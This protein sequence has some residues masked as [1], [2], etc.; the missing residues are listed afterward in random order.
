MPETT[1]LEWKRNPSVTPGGK[2]Y[3]WT[4]WGALGRYTAL[5]D[6]RNQCWSVELPKGD[7][8]YYVRTYCT[9]LAQAKRDAQTHENEL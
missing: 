5:W 2:P 9:S 1:Q 6:R 4:A 7:G 8:T 3:F